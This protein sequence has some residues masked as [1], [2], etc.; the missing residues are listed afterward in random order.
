MDSAKL[1]L[2]V[3]CLNNRL[4]VGS[5]LLITLLELLNGAIVSNF[6]NNTWPLLPISL[7][8]QGSRHLYPTKCISRPDAKLLTDIMPMLFYCFS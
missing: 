8:N 7:E 2:P 4:I 6:S 3:C 5:N 1:L